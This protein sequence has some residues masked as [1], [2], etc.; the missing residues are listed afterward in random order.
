[1][2][3]IIKAQ[4]FKS[5]VPSRRHRLSAYWI[6]VLSVTALLLAGSSHAISFVD[7]V[8]A[9]VGRDVILYSDVMQEMF[10]ELGDPSQLNIDETQLM[11]QIN[12][13]Y[14]EALE[15]EIELRILFNEA[16]TLGVAIP[17]D[18][19]EER[20]GEAKKQYASNEEFQSALKATGLTSS[21]LRDRIRRQMMAYSIRMSKHHQFEK[22]ALI[23]ESDLSQYFHDHKRD[24]RFESRY[25]VRRFF[26][27]A[28]GEDSERE[29][30]KEKLD[31][32]RMEVQDGA[33]FA[34]LA[35]EKSDGPEASDGGI[36][37]WVL[38]GDLVEPLNSTVL[39]LPAGDLSDILET[40][41]GFHFLRVEEIQTEGTTPYEEARMKIEPLLRKEYADKEYRRWM[42]RLRQRS[43]IRILKESIQ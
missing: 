14:K 26:M 10:S 31:T 22:E 4:C 28:P 25:Y 43:D 41:F 17:D 11:E 6:R 5:A 9:T 15:R 34:D 37:G 38:P 8:V 1:M 12:P 24:F 27:K 23:T 33:D 20:I 30:V 18:K 39:S 32:L 35:K 13:L 42:S 21:I 16:E 40:D 19:V 7:G 36:I 29:A 2:K 3:R